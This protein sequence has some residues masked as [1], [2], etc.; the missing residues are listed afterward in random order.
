MQKKKKL[1]VF[2]WHSLYMYYLYSH[3][4]L[5]FRTNDMEMIQFQSQD[6]QSLLAQ[7]HSKR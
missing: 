1:S 3:N 5:F 2:E 7:I 4:Q 6:P